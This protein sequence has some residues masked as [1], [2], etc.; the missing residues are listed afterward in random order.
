MSAPESLSFLNDLTKNI[1]QATEAWWLI[2]SF[3]DPIWTYIFRTQKK[4]I[5]WDIE[6]S[7][8]SSLLS[9]K[10]SELLKSLRV[11]LILSTRNHADPHRNTNSKSTQLICFR[12]ACKIIDLLLINDSHL[13]ISQYGIAGLTSGDFQGILTQISSNSDTNESI[14]QWNSCIQNFCIELYTQTPPHYIDNLIEQ[15]PEI[16]L[17]TPEQID[18]NDLDIPTELIP[19]IRASLYIAGLYHSP[20][21]YEHHLNTAKVS[22][23][24]YRNT[25]L[26]RWTNKPPKSI[27][28]FYSKSD[29]FSREYIGVPVNTFKGGVMRSS[30]VNTFKNLLYSLGK[31]KRYGLAAPSH[32]D[33]TSILRFTNSARPKG[34]F[35]TL[36]SSV[37]FSSLRNAIEFHYEMSGTLLDAL[38]T[39]C[40]HCTLTGAPAS[41]LTEH[42]FGTVCKKLNLNKHGIEKLGLSLRTTGNHQNSVKGAKLDYY[43]NLRNKKGLLELICIYIACTQII[44][45]ALSAKR[46]GE[47]IDLECNDCLDTTHTWLIFLMEKCTTSLYGIQAKAARPIPPIAGEMISTLIKIHYYLETLGGSAS[48]LFATPNLSCAI[49]VES[50]PYTYN[51]NLDLFCDYFQTKLD[52]SGARY[53]IRQHQ[54]RRFFALLFFKTSSVGGLETLQWMLGHTDLMHIWNYITEVID[55]AT[56]QGAKAQHIAEQ[57]HNPQSVEKYH[58]LENLLRDRYD[59]EN[60]YLVDNAYLEAYILDLMSSGEVEIE[61]EFYEDSSGQRLRVIVKILEHY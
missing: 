48:T 57:M 56:L 38:K 25:A 10:N 17:I 21:S 20:T 42:K 58:A 32:S 41:H 37:V 4:T 14:Y 18:E 30:A 3:D 51:R 5:D 1:R 34:R 15:I 53:Y 40:D 16:S 44:V 28:N 43:K 50:A 13:K 9:I 24:L 47:L 55:G 31:L 7:D 19:R 2:S 12:Y 61:P 8:G 11:F 35:R 59:I 54:L 27:L 49:F 45:G 52:D 26:G 39:I 33:L 46:A 29:Q 22:R 6:L 23:K 36:P 60:H